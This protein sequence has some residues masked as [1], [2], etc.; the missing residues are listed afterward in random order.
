MKYLWLGLFFI[1]LIWSGINPKDQFTWLLEVIPAIIGL[2][3]LASSYKHFKL[4]P[5]LYGFILAHCIVL[6]VGGHYTYAEVPWFDNLFGSERNNYDKVGHFFQ[7]FVPALLAREIL[8]RKNVVNGKGWLNVFVVSICLAFS[9]FYELI[10]WW[11]AVLSGENAEA[12]LGTQGYVWDTQSDMGIALLGAICS[13]LLLSK[14]HDKQLK[15]V[16]DY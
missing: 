15:N 3:L 1:V 4:T 5:I 16:K 10:E 6:M 14:V 12:F 7:G 11:V 2:V 13:I 9:A 8:L